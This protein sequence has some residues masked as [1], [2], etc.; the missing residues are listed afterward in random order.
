M[1]T[2]PRRQASDQGD[3]DRSVGPVQPERRV[4]PDS[5]QLVRTVGAGDASER[6]AE[7]VGDRVL[8]GE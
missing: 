3:E 5:Y 2:Q 8:G 6:V 7:V 1:A 4:G